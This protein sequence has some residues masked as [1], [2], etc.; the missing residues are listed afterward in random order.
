MRDLTRGPVGR[1]VLQLS[2]FIAL[3]TFFQTLYLVV[4]LYFVG[5]LGKE[6]VAG[7]AVAGNLMMVVLALTQTL[8]VGATSRIA[9]ALGRQDRAQAA[10]V[11]NQTLVFSALVGLAFG[12]GMGLLRTVYANWLAADAVTAARGVEYLNWY[13]PALAAQFLL[14]GMGAALRGAGDLK[15]P[16]ILQIGTVLLNIVLSPTLM[17]GWVTGRPLGVAG[18]SLASFLSILVGLVAFVVYFQRPDSTLRFAPRHW[19]PQ[20]RLWG[21]MLKVGL[22]VGGEFAVISVFLMLVYAVIR[23]FGAAAQAGFGIG[24]RIM[25]SLFLPAVAVGF[26]TAPVAGQNFGAR[27]GQR[28]RDT[29]SAAVRMATVVMLA[30]TVICQLVPEALVRFFNPDPAVVAVGVEYLRI[31][32]WAYVANGVIFVSSSVFQGMGNTMP[33]LK[34]SMLRMAL[35]AP[36]V[37]WWSGQPGFEIRHIWILSLT[38][39]VIHVSVS[40]WLLFREFTYRLAFEPVADT[41]VS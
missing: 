40:V 1:H 37:L 9:Q 39:V 24:S 28:V 3:S 23:P 16:T 25:Q 26:A 29:F 35:F 32:S 14:V 36:A 22:P 13:I 15:I 17:F 18:A 41:E 20:P 19:V 12:V 31:I 33:A 6:A 38:T 11:F 5:R 4:D 2:A 30:G 27:K 8:G 34:A 10:L 21:G 7:V